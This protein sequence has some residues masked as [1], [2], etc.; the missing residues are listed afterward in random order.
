MIADFLAAFG[1]VF[2]AELPDKTMFAT[3]L[4]STRFPRKSAVW[5]GVTT[6]YSIHVV[7]AT[8]LGGLLSR[9]PEDPVRFAV[10]VL[11]VLAGAYLAWDSWQR[12]DEDAQTVTEAPRSWRSVYTVSVATVGVAEF[13]DITQ[14][15]TASLAATRDAPWAVGAGAAS[16]L[17]LVSGLAVLVG[18]ALTRRVNLK[19]IQRVAGMLFMLIGAAT[20]TPTI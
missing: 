1:V 20:F 17:A 19:L 3:L 16:A 4:L 13:A 7:V 15:A 8:L 10:G 14:L 12:D 9:L 5:C 2:L 6:A 18:S 11:F